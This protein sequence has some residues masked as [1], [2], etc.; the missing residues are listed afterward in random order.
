MTFGWLVVQVR[1]GPEQGRYVPRGFGV[2]FGWLVQRSLETSNGA[3]YHASTT[4][5]QQLDN[6]YKS[7]LHATNTTALDAFLH[8]NLAPPTL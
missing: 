8:H 2:T 3:I 4:T 5:L 1:R 6:L 7:F